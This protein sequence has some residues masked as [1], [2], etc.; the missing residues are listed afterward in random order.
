MKKYQGANR[1][2]KAQLEK[3]FFEKDFVF[4]CDMLDLFGSK[5]R[6]YQIHKILE[7][8]RSSAAQFLLLT[9]NPR[10]YQDFKIPSNAVCGATIETDQRPEIAERI[11]IMT[12][13][14]HPRKMVSVEPIMEFSPGFPSKLLDIEPEF[15]AVGYDNYKCGLK[16]PSLLETN[17]LINYFQERGIQVYEK[18]IREKIIK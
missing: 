18:T 11:Q 4:V 16:E 15:L 3:R 6:L 5:V 7:K 8:I 14:K 2:F 9:K 13:L 10:R 1:I 12:D 17:F